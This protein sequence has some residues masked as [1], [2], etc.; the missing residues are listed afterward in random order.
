MTDLKGNKIYLSKITPENRSGLVTQINDSP[1]KTR[2]LDIHRTA[3][4]ST[5]W[6]EKTTTVA[7]SRIDKPPSWYNFSKIINSKVGKRNKDKQKDNKQVFV[8]SIKL[9]I[10]EK[11]HTVSEF[12]NDSNQNDIKNFEVGFAL[13][14]VLF[15]FTN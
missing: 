2:N 5:V 13:L 15:W 8:K 10:F 12:I 11:K 9:P 3:H 6:D 14:F 4:W 7:K 1:H